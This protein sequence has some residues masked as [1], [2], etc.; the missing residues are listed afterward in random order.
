MNW[1]KTFAKVEKALGF[2]LYEWQKSYIRMDI[3]EIPVGGRGNGKTLAYILRHLLNYEVKYA[4]YS[5]V[6]GKYYGHYDDWYYQPWFIFPCDE[7]PSR[8]YVSRWYP[9]YVID[10]DRLLKEHEIETCFR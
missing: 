10:I 6:S 5:V 7:F 4:D 8:E 2:K 9:R 1:T 3:D